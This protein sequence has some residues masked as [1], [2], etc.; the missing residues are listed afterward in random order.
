MEFNWGKAKKRKPK[1]KLKTGQQRLRRGKK[2][3]SWRGL[4]AKDDNGNF[5][6]QNVDLSPFQ[7]N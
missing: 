4:H 1:F 6:L 3:Q 7:D 2:K 5:I